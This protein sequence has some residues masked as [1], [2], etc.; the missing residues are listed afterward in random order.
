M[1][2]VAANKGKIPNEGETEFEFETGDGDAEC[3]LFQIA[4]VNK[5]LA[6]IA[7]RVDNH[8][9]VVFDKDEEAGKDISYMRN[10]KT[11]RIIKM[12]RTGNV[13]IIEAIVEA[14]SI[15]D[16]SFARRG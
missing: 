5:A 9:R 4:E 14:N 11:K 6:S 12:V 7:D 13:W 8:H 15:G 16:E 1:Q 3:W 10:K 2:Y